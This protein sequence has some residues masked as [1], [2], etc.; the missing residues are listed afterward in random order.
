MWNQH[1]QIRQHRQP[2]DPKDRAF[3]SARRN[4]PQPCVVKCPHQKK[5]RQSRRREYGILD[6]AR[7]P[8]PIRPHCRPGRR[9]LHH[10]HPQQQQAKHAKRQHV[11]RPQAIDR[12]LHIATLSDPTRSKLD[13]AGQIFPKK[14]IEPPRR[15]VAKVELD[16]CLKNP[17]A[18]IEFDPVL[19]FWRLGG[20]I[21]SLPKN[22]W[23]RIYRLNSLATP[24][25]PDKVIT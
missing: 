1:Q 23:T 4:L 20:S 6:P 12:D 7:R 2:Q 17:G 3:P 18:E 5:C 13:L 15:Q 19:A 24:R 25:I 22:R 14:A 16:S 10:H 21:Y 9:R 11:L 8:L